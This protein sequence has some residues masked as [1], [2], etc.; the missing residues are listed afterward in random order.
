MRS[1]NSLDAFNEVAGGWVPLKRIIR[2]KENN[3][4]LATFN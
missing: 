2:D 1:M 3:D 4:D